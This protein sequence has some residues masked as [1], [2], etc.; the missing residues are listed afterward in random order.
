[1]FEM[2][3]GLALALTSVF[4]MQS[5]ESLIIYAGMLMLI[6]GLFLIKKGRDK[7]NQKQ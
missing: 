2:I 3:I 4:L 7:M 1:M 5:S 6:A